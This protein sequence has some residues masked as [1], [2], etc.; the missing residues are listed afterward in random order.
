MTLDTSFTLAPSGRSVNYGQGALTATV[1]AVGF[2]LCCLGFLP[3]YYLTILYNGQRSTQSPS[4]PM[5]PTVSFADSVRRQNH[6]RD[7][8]AMSPRGRDNSFNLRYQNSRQLRFFYS[9]PTLVSYHI[10]QMFASIPADYFSD[11][12]P[13]PLCRKLSE[14]PIQRTLSAD[15]MHNPV[16]AASSKFVNINIRKYIAFSGDMCYNIIGE[17]KSLHPFVMYP[18]HIA[19]Y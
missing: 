16:T 3:C 19:G 10:P 4:A 18:P 8:V 12:S 2:L 6:N 13:P 14:T 15:I 11:F 5:L 7:F 1:S 9:L 17:R